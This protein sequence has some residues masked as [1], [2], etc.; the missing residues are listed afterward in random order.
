MPTRKQSTKR[1]RKQLTNRNEP[2]AAS[3]RNVSTPAEPGPTGRAQTS[4]TEHNSPFAVDLACAELE[5][6]PVDWNEHQQ[7]LKA[8]VDELEQLGFDAAWPPVLFPLRT[9]VRELL[10]RARMLLEGHGFEVANVPDGLMNPLGDGKTWVIKCRPTAKISPN[11]D[12]AELV[13]RCLE[14]QGVKV[15]ARPTWDNGFILIPLCEISRQNKATSDI[16]PPRICD[17]RTAKRETLDEEDL[18]ERVNRKLNNAALY[19]YMNAREVMQA[20]GLSRS[21]VYDHPSLEAFQTGSKKR[22]WYTRS[23]L[24]LLEGNDD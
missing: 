21:K 9:D 12:A 5:P 8:R 10:G 2:G 13:W 15:A 18:A 7:K 4:E 6:P 16:Q 17:S 20:T 14:S 3:G 23:V 24:D 22:Q 11:Q 19:P 1:G